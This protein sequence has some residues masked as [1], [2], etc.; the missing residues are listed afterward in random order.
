[1]SYT[2]DYLIEAIKSTGVSQTDIDKALIYQSKN[3]GSI[4]NLLVNLGSLTEDEL[5]SIYSNALK[6]KLIEELPEVTQEAVDKFKAKLNVEFLIARKWLP[7]SFHNDKYTFVTSTPFEREVLQYF[8]I[9][10]VEYDLNITSPEQIEKASVAY[11]AKDTSPAD[12]EVFS[13][14][15]ELEE[16]K[17][18]E[19]AAEAPTVNLLNSY[20]SKGL[21]IGAS[22]MH[23]EPSKNRFRVRYRVDGVLSEGELVPAKYQLAVVSRLK[24]LS[25]MDIAEKRRPQDGKIE[26]K[27]AN[28]ELDIRVSVLPLNDG[29]SVVMRFLKKD[30]V[31]YDIEAV[32]LSEDLKSLIVEDLA[33]T[34]GVILMTGP[35]GSGKTTTLYTFLNRLNN[36]DVKI[37]TLEDPVEY[38]LDGVNQ[39]Q[40]NSEIGFDFESGLRSIV[41]QDPD[42]IML[43]EIRDKETARIAMQSALTGHLVFSTVHTNDAPSAFTRLLDLG[44]EEY[45]LNAA[46]IS[47]VAQRL[48][49]KLC[50]HCAVPIEDNELVTKYGLRKLFPELDITL[51]KPVGCPEC[52]HMGY[53]GRTA[54]IEYLRCTEELKALNKSDDFIAKAKVLNKESGGRTLLEDGLLKVTKGL[55]TIDEVLRVAG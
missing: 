7:I 32:G 29:E 14:L 2:S 49:R 5:P 48:A 16:G 54:I 25:G 45:L 12:E 31:T 8:T 13:V 11:S 50:N 26:T 19:L 21:K 10:N 40:I 52:N 35:T 4:E 37:I 46:I 34:A 1:M 9:E 53:K 30:S 20:I 28:V 41:R 22:D 38:Q 44:V 24:I 3:G 33:S 15:S 47:I 39:V 43:G 17:L 23:I 42:I 36:D 27:I 18:R 55:T 51:R 6:I